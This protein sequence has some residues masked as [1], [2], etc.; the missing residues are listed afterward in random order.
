MNDES[1]QLLMTFDIHH[2]LNENS[3]EFNNLCA[4]GETRNP[5]VFPPN[6]V[7]H[8]EDNGNF[9][10]S[11]SLFMHWQTHLFHDIITFA[12]LL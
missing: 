12:W 3:F 10:R 7:I 1:L 5:L 6:S 8:A 11:K 9:L 2:I 4:F